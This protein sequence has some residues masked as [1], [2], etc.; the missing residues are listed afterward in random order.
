MLGRFKYLK[1]SLVFILAFVGVKMILAH[2][3]PIPTVASL[4]VIIG[5][6]IVGI[7]ASALSTAHARSK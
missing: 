7:L 6:L 3:Q 1:Q 2:H 5:I 4:G